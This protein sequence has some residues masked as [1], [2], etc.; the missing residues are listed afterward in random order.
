[1]ASVIALVVSLAVG[2]TVIIITSTCT[3][4]KLLKRNRMYVYVHI[5]EHSLSNLFVL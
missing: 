4:Y 1:M 2:L 5:T 3:S